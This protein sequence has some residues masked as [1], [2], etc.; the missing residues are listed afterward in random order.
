MTLLLA[1]DPGLIHP[2]AALFHCGV[3]VGASRVRVP[4]KLS[5]L[6]VADRCAEIGDLIV[7]WALDAA[8]VARCSPLVPSE[9]ACEWPQI[10]A[11]G[12]GKGDPNNLVPLAAI[13]TSV[14]SRV[15]A[16]LSPARPAVSSLM[17]GAIWGNAL[18]KVE[19]GDPLSSPRGKLVWKRLSEGERAVVAL[20]HDALDAVGIGLKKLERLVLRV[21]PGAT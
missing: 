7:E 2:A 21:Y 4:G 11:H 5:K 3:L 12:K 13:C 16:L 14:V 17:P 18:P 9:V 10:Y 19:T 8:S 20:S 1:V 6:A 15:R